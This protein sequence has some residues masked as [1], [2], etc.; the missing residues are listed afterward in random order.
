[1]RC[2]VFCRYVLALL[3]NHNGQ[4]KLNVQ[5]IRICRPNHL[6][7]MSNKRHTIAFIIYWLLIPNFRNLI[8][9]A[10][11]F[12]RL[13]KAINQMLFKYQT[14][15]ILGRH[16]RCAKFDITHVENRFCFWRFHQLPRQSQTSL[17]RINQRQH[18]AKWVFNTARCSSQIKQAVIVNGCNHTIL[19]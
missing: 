16:N 10:G 13:G 18:I 8:R 9:R 7:L 11:H 19:I 4:L 12:F 1:M 3:A 6:L 17:A 2:C 5:I 14:I 15:P